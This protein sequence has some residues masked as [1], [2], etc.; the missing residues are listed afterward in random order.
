VRRSRFTQP[1]IAECLEKHKSGYTAE[2]LSKI[3]GISTSTLYVWKSRFGVDSSPELSVQEKLEIE[4]RRLRHR[5]AE[6]L[7]END[8]L[9]GLIRTDRCG[10]NL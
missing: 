10:A 2:E 3:Y 4:N 7:E 5:I 1:E 6:M 8:K 9:K